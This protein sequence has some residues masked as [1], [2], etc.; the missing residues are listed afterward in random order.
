MR[1]PWDS[2]FAEERERGGGRGG[3][4]PERGDGVCSLHQEQEEHL[5]THAS[6]ITSKGGKELLGGPGLRFLPLAFSSLGMG[7]RR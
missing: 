1:L 5:A 6:L 4:A 3:G 7:P 2:K